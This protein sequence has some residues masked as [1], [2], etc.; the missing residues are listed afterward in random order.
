MYKLNLYYMYV[1]Y[2]M[3]YII[4]KTTINLNISPVLLFNGFTR[5]HKSRTQ[6]GTTNSSHT[7]IAKRA[8]ERRFYYDMVFD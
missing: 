7:Q 8:L 5:S 4:K 2:C 3:K 6:A 1:W